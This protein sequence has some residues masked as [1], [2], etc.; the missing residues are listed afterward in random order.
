MTASQR[1]SRHSRWIALLCAVALVSGAERATAQLQVDPQVPRTE[2][3]TVRA[4]A[5]AP[6]GSVYIGGQFRSI[7]GH[8]T[9]S[10]ARLTPDLRLDRN[11]RG[12]LVLGDG[13]GIANAVSV[14]AHAPPDAGGAT[15][16]HLVVGGNFRINA[17][18][19]HL[20]V[21][22][23]STGREAE[24]VG[25]NFDGPI[26]AMHATRVGNDVQV[27]AS[28]EFDFVQARA[29]GG[30]V[31]LAFGVDLPLPLGISVD[32]SLIDA[33][34]LRPDGSG[35]IAGRFT[36]VLSGSTPTGLRHLIRIT[37]NGQ[38][39]PSFAPQPNGPV[40]TLALDAEQRLY[41]GGAFS[42][43]DGRLAGRIARFTADDSLD[44]GFGPPL[45]DGSV[46]AV[47]P[48]DHGGVLVTGD[49]TEVALQPRPGLALLGENGLLAD[50]I[51]D[52]SGSVVA[53]LPVRGGAL[54]AGDITLPGSAEAL[55]LAQI[56]EDG[57]ARGNFDPQPNDRVLTAA[58]L[59]EGGALIGGRFTS[60]GDVTQAYLARLRAGGGMD[61]A[62]APVLDGAVH[63]LWVEADGRML[64]GGEFSTV[65]GQ[66]RP[67]VARL[68]PDGSLDSGFQLS[69]GAP[70]GAVTSLLRLQNGHYWI[71]GEF[72]QIG[73][74]SRP[75]LSEITGNGGVLSAP[76]RLDAA[77][78]QLLE[79]NPGEV[80]VAGGFS[81][82]NETARPGLALH[83]AGTGLDTGFAPAATG[84]SGEVALVHGIAR[85]SGNPAD[86]LYGGQFSS[87]FGRGVPF[88]TPSIR[89][90]PGVSQPVGAVL[91]R[92]D[93]V[94]MLLTTQAGSS[95]LREYDFRPEL[96]QF[97]E[98]TLGFNG[99][100][101][102][103]APLA[104]GSLLAFGDFTNVAGIPRQRLARVKAGTM[105]APSLID[106]LVDS[107]VTEDVVELRLIQPWLRSGGVVVQSSSDGSAW[108]DLEVD[109]SQD[110][111]TG[112]TTV[113]LRE[114]A[115]DLTGRP[116][117]LRVLSRPAIGPGRGA[118]GLLGTRFTG[119]FDAV[120]ISVSSA[121]GGSAILPRALPESPRALRTRL[122]KAVV[123]QG[124][125]DPGMRVAGFSGCEPRQEVPGQG[126]LN[127]IAE[128]D[129]SL[130]A[131]FEPDLV[132][133][134]PSSGI[135]GS[136]TPAQPVEVLRGDRID[137]TLLPDLG[138]SIDA[139][140]GSCPG[141]LEGDRYTAG[142]IPDDCTVTANWVFS[143][144]RVIPE[145][146]AGGRVL[147]DSPQVGEAG[148]SFDFDILADTG[149]E[150]AGATGDCPLGAFSQGVQS[151][152]PVN[153]ECTF[154]PQFQRQ[155]LTVTAGVRGN[156]EISP[157][158]AT[159]VPYGDSAAY[160]LLPANG[161][162]VSAIESDCPFA[163]EGDRVVA[164]P[165][166]SNCTLTAV[167][168]PLSFSVEVS[169]GPGGRVL[170]N[171]IQTVAFGQTLRVELMPDQG[172]E[173]ASAESSCGGDLVDNAFLTAPITQA[174]SVSVSFQAL[175][176]RVFESGF[177]TPTEQ[178]ASPLA[179]Q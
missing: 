136:L 59:P 34:L 43:I 102:G 122:G 112:S 45:F 95:V 68:L 105:R 142:P 11:L 31:R 35:Y 70:N 124:N 168:E 113:F 173:V 178:V 53:A 73:G 118:G 132:T 28:G 126:S 92:S 71:G 12:L 91:A 74:L 51:P 57:S 177:E 140:V 144:S 110:G 52:A 117:R 87:L 166:V 96:V 171:G 143:G 167:F 159:A 47:A 90:I 69:A 50:A 41:V 62:F 154:R 99:P 97:T 4:L 165:I 170:P 82:V 147:P 63:A 61:E 116:L 114:P 21:I 139:V 160:T 123:V 150:Y 55:G 179:G 56:L 174:C 93:A 6:D 125:P 148:A 23:L 65:N 32:A 16:P 58:G 10:L 89:C 60:V 18:P 101:D 131:H 80:L 78:S 137:F 25:F 146:G 175:P 27:L 42:Q 84:G 111:A 145:A 149:F 94:P 49:F 13:P 128:R 120:N 48:L 3:A 133:V 86:A 33:L 83:R 134:T 161:Q 162:R 1:R 157:A 30:L 29:T 119:R 9:F 172:F 135:G 107:L 44:P 5:R 151:V 115:G 14:V 158:G 19:E 39:D 156:G 38:L 79:I 127:F 72:T 15:E 26:R 108:T 8:G 153:G 75:R 76:L 98:E 163:Q 109:S 164:G 36:E 104:D 176:A 46:R 37:P 100:V 121:G 88:C 22:R 130:V 67:G 54:L 24:D 141:L 20:L 169:S 103:L 106:N 77:P 81:Q 155:T 85:I 40:H 17:G 138:Y 2:P 152:G 129:C 66:S 7:T 64:I